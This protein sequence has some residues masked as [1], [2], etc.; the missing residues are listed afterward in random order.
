M[1]KNSTKALEAKVAELTEALQRERADAINIRRRADEDRLKLAGLFKA[2]VVETFLP[3]IDG[4]ELALKH[5]PKDLAGHQYIKGVQS[6][7]KQFDSAL[8]EAGV[9]KIKTV[10]EVFNPNL[11]EAVGVEEGDGQLELICEEVQAG[12]LLGDTV[13]RHAKVKVKKG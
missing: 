1:P 6:V 11:H 5:T 8:E 10:G 7:A 13:I 9:S 12:Y 3:A 2:Q 4:L